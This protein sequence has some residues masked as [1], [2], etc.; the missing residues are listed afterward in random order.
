MLIHDR[1]HGLSA[2]LP[3]YQGAELQPGEVLVNGPVQVF[4]AIVLIS[5]PTVM[6]GGF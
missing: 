3:S 6:F 1:F 5:L 4:A 2:W